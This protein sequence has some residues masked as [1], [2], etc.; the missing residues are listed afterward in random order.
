MFAIIRIGPKQFKVKVGDV[1]EVDKLDAK[2][3]DVL[4]YPALLTA[5]EKTVSIGKP[6]VKG[7]TVKAKVLAQTMGEKISVRRYKSKVHYRRQ[8]GFRAKL[9]KLEITDISL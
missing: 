3:G 6:E 5:K 9:T 1:I 2:D 7:A 8:T 4:S